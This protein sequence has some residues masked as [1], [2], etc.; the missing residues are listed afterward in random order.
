MYINNCSTHMGT[1][2]AFIL[3]NI[4]TVTAIIR[5]I[6]TISFTA[7]IFGAA[8]VLPVGTY[9]WILSRRNLQASEECLLPLPRRNLRSR[10]LHNV[11]SLSLGTGFYSVCK[12][13]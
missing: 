12:F 11:H 2:R 3:T 9:K 5:S 4:A 1:N 8:N 10:K 7:L 13:L 6:I